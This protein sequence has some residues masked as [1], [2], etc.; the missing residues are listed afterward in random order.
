MFLDQKIY[1]NGLLRDKKDIPG[2]EHYTNGWLVIIPNYEFLEKK[3]EILKFLKSIFNAI[4]LDLKDTLILE[5]NFVM[6]N[7]IGIISKYIQ[8]KNILVFG[9]NTTQIGLKFALPKYEFFKI[10]SYNLLIADP[11]EEIEL[12]VKLKKLLWQALK[13]KI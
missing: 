4:G 3:E 11:L 13:E 9:V 7:H 2:I 5:E 6:Y 10:S 8:L 1:S 12:N